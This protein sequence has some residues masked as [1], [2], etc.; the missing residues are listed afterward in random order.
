MTTLRV[1]GPENV[2]FIHTDTKGELKA[3]PLFSPSCPLLFV[4]NLAAMAISAGLGNW[5][6]FLKQ[7]TKGVRTA[8]HLL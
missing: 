6:K 1:S 5:Q 4:S 2:V 7:S 8:K 3:A